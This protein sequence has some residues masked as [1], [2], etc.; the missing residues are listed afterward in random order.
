MNQEERDWLEWL[1]RAQDGVVTQR[2]AA[3]KMGV[4]DRWVRKLLS[5]HEDRWRRSCGARSSGTASNRRIEEK[6][7]RERSSYLKQPEWHDFGPTFASEQLAK[8]HDI[9]VSKETV[10]AWMVAGRG[11]GKRN[12][13]SSTRCIRGGRGAA[14]TANWCSGTLRTTIGWK[15][16]ASL[17]AT[18]CGLI[19]DATSRSWGR[20]VQHDGTRENMG[21]LWEYLERNG[22]MVD[23]YTDRAAMFMV[24][25]QANE[26]RGSSGR[27]PTGLTQIGRAL[28]ELGIGWIPAYSPQAKGRV[29]RSFGTD[30]DRLVKQLRLA[31]VTTL[32]A[33]NEFLEKEYWPE[34][35]ERFAHPLIGVVDL[36]RALTPQLDLASSLSHVEHSVITND[37][38]FPFFTPELPDCQGGPT[39]G[40][41]TKEFACRAWTERRT[42]SSVRGS[43]CSDQRVRSPGSVGT[44]TASPAGAQGSQSR[45]QERMDARLLRAARAGVVASHTNSQREDLSLGKINPVNKER[46]AKSAR[47][48][49]RLKYPKPPL[50]SFTNSN[51]SPNEEKPS[52]REL[53]RA[54]EG[55]RR[56]LSEPTPSHRLWAATPGATPAQRTEN[57]MAGL[58]HRPKPERSTL[59]ATG[60]FYFALTESAP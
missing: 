34:W 16:A 55:L 32:Q 48:T 60:T 38:T 13:A 22:R 21:V 9:H 58:H 57:T 47:R 11:S 27:R 59:L 7:R 49:S 24:T 56:L 20:F 40:D 5:A 44:E 53:G 15:A 6:T 37:Y 17:C 25:P 45:R 2:Q 33:A 23:V 19:D 36:H 35:N 51:Q 46:R 10:R 39:S 50:G 18:W 8:R 12:R 30:Q 3:E 29:E 41:A 26:E 42:Q 31:K 54:E 43:V 4:S 1:K 14:A 28:R 52:R